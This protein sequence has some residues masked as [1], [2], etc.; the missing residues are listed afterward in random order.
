MKRSTMERVL[1]GYRVKPGLAIC[2]DKPIEKLLH[3]GWPR[4][5][6][7]KTSFI[8]NDVDPF[9]LMPIFFWL[10]GN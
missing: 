4:T 9:L 3:G 7:P 5:Y 1:T 6:F 2:P 10:C 8:K